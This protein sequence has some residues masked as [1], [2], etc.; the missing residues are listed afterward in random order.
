MAIDLLLGIGL[1][2]IEVGPILPLI[3][4]VMFI[5][6]LLRFEWVSNPEQY[7]DMFRSRQ[8]DLVLSFIPLAMILGSLVWGTIQ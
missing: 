4:G 5:T 7:D 2:L 8:L 6:D 3:C 1:V